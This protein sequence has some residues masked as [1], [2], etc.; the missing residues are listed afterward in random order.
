M[1]DTA[2]VVIGG[3]APH[4]GVVARLP[5][6]RTVIAADSG[7][8]HADA[9]GI[10][11][12]LLVGDLD[13]VSAAALARHPRLLI[14]RH[15]TDK[16]A[17]DTELALD[18]ALASGHHHVIV[19]S[20]GGD[21]LDHLL[22]TVN[23]C[24]RIGRDVRLEAWVG[25]AHVYVLADGAHLELDARVGDVVT[26]LP[27]DGAAH[28]VTASGLRWPLEGETLVWGSSRGV[29]NEVTGSVAIGVT[30]G[31]LAVIFPH[32]LPA[33]PAQGGHP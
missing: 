20:G 13:S 33:D 23:V 25:A 28:G 2:V 19:V 26:L 15:P 24:A 7:L 4:Q 5:V 29:S 14:E 32:A 1:P 27:L 6:D 9:L 18:A 17:T 3:D 10:E 12:H 22:A 21:R 8:D 11:T 30:R 31:L 16:D